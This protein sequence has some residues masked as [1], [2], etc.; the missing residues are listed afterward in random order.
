VVGSSPSAG[1]AEIA[2]HRFGGDPVIVRFN[3]KKSADA[4]VAN[5][6]ASLE[7]T[8]RKMNPHTDVLLLILTSHGSPD[9]LAVTT[10]KKGQSSPRER[11][12][13][14]STT[15]ASLIRP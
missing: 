12:A 2:A 3:S 15:W 13:A 14:F 8:A 7:T 10:G 5:L 9:G 11:S 4:T 6:A 1:A